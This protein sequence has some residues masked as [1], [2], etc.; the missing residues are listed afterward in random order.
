MRQFDLAQIDSLD[1][2]VRRLRFLIDDLFELSLSDVG[3]LRYSFSR[4]N[5]Q[6][7]I[8][9]AMSAGTSRAKDIGLELALK[10]DDDVFIS[11]DINRVDQ[12]LQNLFENSLAYTDAPGRIEIILSKNHQ[13]A[14][15]EIHDT[16]PGATE[17][18]CVQLF[19]PFF[20]R[21]AS[22]NRREG[23][24]GL[25]LAICRNIVEAHRG[26]ISASPSPRGGLCIHIEI[27]AE[28]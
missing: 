7:A 3:G 2:E 22:R 17:L 13:S 27:P 8:H 12:L 15:I 20:R 1:Q 24:T 10:G 6:E 14:V 21:E 25:G 5:L 28:T 11:G 4:L 9:A 19:E 23:G 26:T 16:A 18:E